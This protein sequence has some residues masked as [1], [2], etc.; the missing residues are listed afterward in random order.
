MIIF[1]TLIFFLQLI[2]FINSQKTNISYN[3]T[4]LK[5][6]QEECDTTEKKY[7]FEIECIINPGPIFD[8]EFDLEL[9]SPKGV[10]A[11]CKLIDD[12]I[13]LIKCYINENEFKKEKFSISQDKLI[14][15]N[16]KIN[17]YIGK[18]KQDWTSELCTFQKLYMNK[19]LLVIILLIIFFN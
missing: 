15:V 19:Y 12:I 2:C 11:K 7:N 16:D 18:L 14:K 4:L 13:D 17:I 1:F 5:L 6:K 8:L 10:I 3:I 9:T